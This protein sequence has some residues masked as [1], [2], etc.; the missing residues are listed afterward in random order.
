MEEIQD[1]RNIIINHILLTYKH[2]VY[3]SRNFE[4]LHFIGLKNY[5]LKTKILEERRAQNDL[6]KKQNSRLSAISYKEINLKIINK[7][8]N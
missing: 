1:Q 8:K 3:P 2:N 5:I 7:R 4:S 6:H